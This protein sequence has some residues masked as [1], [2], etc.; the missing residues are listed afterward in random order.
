MKPIVLSVFNLAFRPFFLLGSLLALLGVGLWVSALSGHP[1]GD[2]P[3]GG[4]LVWHQHE[5]VFGFTGAIIGGFL[6]TAVQSWTGRP[7]LAGFPL[8]LLVLLWL[9]GRISWFQS[10]PPVLLL[11][12][13]LSFLLGVA[14]VMA[15]M[16]WAVRQARNYPI[17]LVLLLLTGVQGMQL[18]GV[19]SGDYA[20]AQ[21]AVLAAIWLVAAMMGLIGGRVIPFFTQRGLGHEQGV[22][23]WPWLDWA[24]L[25]GSVLVAVLF[26]LGFALYPHPLTGLLFGLLAAGH[27]VRLLRWFSPALLRVPLLWS[28]HLAYAW[29]VLAFAGAAL[30]QCG[31]LTNLS[32]LVHALTVGG[33][34]GMILAMLAR[35]TLGHTGRALTLPRGFVAALVLINLA[36]VVRVFGVDLWYL[37]SLWL[38]AV[39]WSAAFG[40][41]LI[42]YGPMLLRPRPDGKAG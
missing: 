22:S 10:I 15:R 17:V 12:L 8:A 4:W 16:L 30:W 20:L 34:G 6:L 5:L 25:L 13:N 26:A 29:M 1:L 23:A 19:A 39:S 41:Y 21:R 36:A 9:L 11:V 27:M 18:Y 24:L 3:V 31:W 40:L 38:A 42:V 35:V 2:Q 28:L 37:P 33:I 7:G 14:V 32:T